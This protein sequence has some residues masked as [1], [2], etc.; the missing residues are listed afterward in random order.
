MWHNITVKREIEVAMRRAVEE[1]ED[2]PRKRSREAMRAEDGDLVA[3]LPEGLKIEMGRAFSLKPTP[4]ER[5]AMVL[6]GEGDEN[7]ILLQRPGIP[8]PSPGCSSQGTLPGYELSEGVVDTPP[9]S[10]EPVMKRMKRQVSLASV[11]VGEDDT[12]LARTTPVLVMNESLKEEREVGDHTGGYLETV[13]TKMEVGNVFDSSVPSRQSLEKPPKVKC[14]ECDTVCLK[15]NLR[16]HML[17]H[18]GKKVREGLEQTENTKSSKVSPGLNTSGFSRNGKA[19][20]YPCN[21]EDCDRSYVNRESLI[22]HKRYDHEKKLPP[23]LEAT[24][25]CKMPQCRKIFVYKNNLSRH[26]R[27][28]HGG[29]KRSSGLGKKAEEDTFVYA[30][31]INI[32]IEDGL[33]NGENFDQGDGGQEENETMEVVLDTTRYFEEGAN[34][35]GVV[36]NGDEGNGNGQ[37]VDVN[38]QDQEKRDGGAAVEGEVENYVLRE[39]QLEDEIY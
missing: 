29:S 2:Q 27:E 14:E 8:W 38:E 11:R 23:K 3:K 34:E 33:D 1:V 32:D 20:P 12:M 15:G 9:A 10:G 18:S 25:P 16:R 7:L 28:V 26:I 39:D 4:K 5:V 31:E 24:F 21:V 19:A 35:V 22:R 30:E 37:E 13:N 17:L 36:F 6:N